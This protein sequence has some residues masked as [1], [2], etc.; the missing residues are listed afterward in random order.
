MV[1]LVDSIPSRRPPVAMW[2]LILLNGAVFA[3]ELTLTPAQLERLFY[4]FGVVPARFMYPEWAAAVGL[5]IPTIWPLLTSMFLHGGW[6]HFIGNMWTL[7]IFGDNVEDRMGPARFLIFYLLCGIVSGLTHL[8]ANPD[9]TVPALGASGAIAGVMGAYF[10]MFPYARVIV[11]VPMLFW[12]FFFDVSAYFYLGFWFLIQLCS[13][14]LSLGADAGGGG[15]AWWAHIGGFASGVGLFWLFIAPSR[16][17]RAYQDDE[18]GFEQ[19][20]T[21]GW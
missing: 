11:M 1:P 7:W 19:A 3:F 16:A 5:P 21:R 17:R 14:M 9:S 6:I 20:W 4:L 10:V 2:L 12:P 15:I 13:G 18:W 8:L